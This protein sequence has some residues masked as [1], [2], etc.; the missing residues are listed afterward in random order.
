M[1]VKIKKGILVAFGELFLKSYPVQVFFRKKLVRNIYFFLKKNKLEFN[2]F[3]FRERI[4]IE[5][6]NTKK[7]GKILKNI[8]GIFW[9]SESLFFEK[10]S[11]DDVS[12][13]I[14]ENYKTWIRKEETFAIRF[15]KTVKTKESSLEIIEKT[16]ERIER[17]V[18]LEKPK[19]EIFIE[20]RKYGWFLYFKKK[21]CLGGLPVGSGE[22][23]LALISGGIDS[24]VASYLIAKRGSENIWLHFHSF[25]LTS[26][27]SI[28][29][30]KETA[31]I[32]L[33]YQPGLKI[34]FFPFAEIQSDVKIKIPPKYRVLVYRRLM[35]RI[36]EKIA[37]KENCYALITG[38]SLGQVSSQ[39]VPNIKITEKAVSIPV[40][41]PLIGMDKQEIINLSKKI[42]TF[43]IST[44]P[45]EDACTLFTPKNASAKGNLEDI[46]KM[47][48]TI[49]FNKLIKK[50]LKKVEVIKK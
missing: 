17:K 9:I 6:N 30:V 36:A 20:A 3:S 39:T 47:E 44:K 49:N 31:E 23:V 40:L 38:E 19:K 37:E 34:Y 27:K 7:A 16:A 33:N 18:D 22:K 11:I 41:R 10:A 21:K 45:Q 15:K 28:E 5:T 1:K 29:K 32:F 48:K 14:F 2:I 13:F 43:S 25:P 4:F 46:E 12:N 50:S 8:F 42:K 26:K 35:L 24:P